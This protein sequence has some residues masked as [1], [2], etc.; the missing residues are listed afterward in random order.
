MEKEVESVDGQ[1]DNEDEKDGTKVTANEAPAP[2]RSYKHHSEGSCIFG[3]E[4]ADMRMNET[5]M[6]LGV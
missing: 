1:E 5:P 3:A 4:L 2:V 6:N